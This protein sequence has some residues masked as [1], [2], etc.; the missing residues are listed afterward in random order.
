MDIDVIIITSIISTNM[1]D[2]FIPLPSRR[3][4]FQYVNSFSRI[5]FYP[6]GFSPASSKSTIRTLQKYDFY[7]A[8]VGKSR[9]VSRAKGSG[10]VSYLS[11]NLVLFLARAALLVSWSRLAPF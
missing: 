9:Y 3:W 6:L 7:P 10:E 5:I 1:R 2:V 11:R 4:S 8:N